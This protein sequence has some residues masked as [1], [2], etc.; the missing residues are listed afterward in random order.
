MSQF[1]DDMLYLL[2][3]I[4]YL[5]TEMLTGEYFVRI[6]SEIFD[7]KVYSVRLEGNVDGEHIVSV[8]N[9]VGTYLGYGRASKFGLGFR[10]D[11]RC[12]NW[13]SYELDEMHR[14]GSGNPFHLD[15][16]GKYRAI[17]EVRVREK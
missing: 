1:F 6:L 14:I 16:R 15:N 2:G 12:V 8:F 13:R 17:R 4:M 3:G 5:F 10:S 9:K 7:R 11:G